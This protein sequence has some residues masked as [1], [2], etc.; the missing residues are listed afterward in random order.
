MNRSSLP[1]KRSEAGKHTFTLELSVA[2][3]VTAVIVTAIALGWV[4]VFGM[5]VGRGQNPENQMPELAQ[6]LP[7]ETPKKAPEDIL[8]AEEL[9][10]MTDLRKPDPA[11][12]DTKN[13]TEPQTQAASP[14]VQ[15]ASSPQTQAKAPVAEEKPAETVQKPIVYD[16]VFQLAAYKKSEQADTLREKL[17]GDNLRTRLIMDRAD[18][19]TVSWYKVQVRFRGSD[20][21]IEALRPRFVKFG[22]KDAMLISKEPVQ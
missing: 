3:C 21:A 12:V 22:L 19:G 13:D 17:E 9:T 6:L 14:P 1:K 7:E 11:T 18:N 5:I 2:G 4:F 16:A 10:F 15:A 8:Q 20:D